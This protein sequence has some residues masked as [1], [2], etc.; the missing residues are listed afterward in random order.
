MNA[1]VPQDAQTGQASAPPAAP[2]VTYHKSLEHMPLGHNEL[3]TLRRRACLAAELHGSGFK[4]TLKIIDIKVSPSEGAKRIKADMEIKGIT[5]LSCDHAFDE[6]KNPRRGAVAAFLTTATF[7]STV[8]S[9]VG[10]FGFG[11]SFTPFSATG[12]GI[13]L[14]TCTGGLSL[15]AGGMRALFRDASDFFC[16]QGAFF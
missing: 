4:A 12:M 2:L 10:A 6:V 16:Q 15:V 8:A 5:S 14:L 7:C 13:G 1:I 11:T 9:L 3:V